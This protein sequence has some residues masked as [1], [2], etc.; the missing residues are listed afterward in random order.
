MFVCAVVVIRAVCSE[1]FCCLVGSC[2]LPVCVLCL[3]LCGREHVGV[4]MCACVCFQLE[5]DVIVCVVTCA[6]GIKARPPSTLV[7]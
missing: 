5:P 7:T 3:C 4:R 2:L 1:L 6:D